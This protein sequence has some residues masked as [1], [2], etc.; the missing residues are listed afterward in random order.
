M[1]M[2]LPLQDLRAAVPNRIVYQGRLTKSGVSSSG[3][4]VFRA[5]FLSAAGAEL[6][7]SGNVTRL[8]TSLPPSPLFSA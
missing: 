4:H 5:R 2:L 8:P 7:N 6:W 1:L 3:A